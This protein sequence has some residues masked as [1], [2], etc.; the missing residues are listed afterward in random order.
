M[1]EVSMT[2]PETWGRAAFVL[3]ALDAVALMV[4]AWLW[5]GSASVT[6]IGPFG[7]WG[8]L[9]P[10]SLLALGVL[11]FWVQHRMDEEQRL[12]L[13]GLVL[14]VATVLLAVPICFYVLLAIAVVTFPPFP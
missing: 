2:S 1:G 6:S 4:M 3:A 8:W 5:F 13:E 12:R 7:P 14:G 10:A 9:P 11:G